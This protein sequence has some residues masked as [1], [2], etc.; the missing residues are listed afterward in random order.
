[1]TGSTFTLTTL[2]AGTDTFT[3]IIRPTGAAILGIGS[4]VERPDLVWQQMMTLSSTSIISVVEAFPPQPFCKPCESCLNDTSFSKAYDRE[5]ETHP[6]RGKAN[7]LAHNLR[8]IDE[9]GALLA[10]PA[11]TDNEAGPDRIA[12]RQ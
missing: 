9:A 10:D 1:V 8:I 3:P 2:G 11:L 6:D 7:F 5:A 4:I 12:M